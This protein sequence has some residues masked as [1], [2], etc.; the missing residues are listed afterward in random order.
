MSRATLEALVKLQMEALNHHDPAALAEQHALNGIVESPMFATLRGRKA[1]EQSYRTFL[2][3]FPDVK[4]VLD[5]AVID[6]PRVAIFLKFNATHA[7]EFYGLPGTHK[8][9]HVTMARLRTTSESGLIAHERRIYDFTG[10][11][12]QTGVLRAKPAKV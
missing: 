8:H 1:I 12:V 7:G 2:T 11:L 3:A 4:F 5:T 6:E 10:M 9:I